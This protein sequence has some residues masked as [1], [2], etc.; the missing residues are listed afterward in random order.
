MASP[1]KKDGSKPPAPSRSCSARVSVEV[2]R[3]VVRL[4][5]EDLTIPAAT[6]PPAN[7]VVI[8]RP[9]KGRSKRRRNK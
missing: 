5:D 1:P 9:G 2:G 4:Q 6:R 7:R 8:F 3:S